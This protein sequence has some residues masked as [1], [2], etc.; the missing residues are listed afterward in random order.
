M[1]L[2]AITHLTSTASVPVA[3][4]ASAYLGTRTLIMLTATFGS[5]TLSRRARE[6][7]RLLRRE[8][9]PR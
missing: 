9:H 2:A 4:A 3:I 1:E 7:L 8:H 5:E 6:V